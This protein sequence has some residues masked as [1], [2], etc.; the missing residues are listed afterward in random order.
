VRLAQ[1]Q[2]V[3]LEL[4]QPELQL[5]EPLEREHLFAQHCQQ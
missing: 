3:Q 1:Q 2:Q 5:P 4:Q